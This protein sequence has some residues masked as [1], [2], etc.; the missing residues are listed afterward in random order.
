MPAAF[1]TSSIEQSTRPEAIKN[2]P[3]LFVLMLSWAMADDVAQPTVD[4]T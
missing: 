3:N 4:A 1:L 2:D